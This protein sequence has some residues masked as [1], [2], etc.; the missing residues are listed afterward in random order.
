MSAQCEGGILE[1]LRSRIPASICLRL[2]PGSA[3]CMFGQSLKDRADTVL[4]NQA[5]IVTFRHVVDTAC[6]GHLVIPRRRDCQ[7]PRS[8]PHALKRPEC[9]PCRSLY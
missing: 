9:L 3:L 7:P 2:M 4:P 8:D 5:A 1:R 6:P